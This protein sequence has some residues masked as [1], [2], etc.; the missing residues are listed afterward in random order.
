M[1]PVEDLSLRTAK[2]KK[3]NEPKRS[4]YS[5]FNTL[6]N[7]KRLD[8]SFNVFNLTVCRYA[9]KVFRVDLHA[10]GLVEHANAKTYS[11]ATM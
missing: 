11:D 1:L 2:R 3:K 6:Q 10:F 4:E 8:R 9:G 7:R 5:N